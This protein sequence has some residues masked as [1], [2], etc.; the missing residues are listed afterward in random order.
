MLA[1]A[2][3]LRSRDR[4]RILV[5]IAILGCNNH[6]GTTSVDASADATADGASASPLGLTC[7]AAIAPN[8]CPAPA[9]TAGQASFCFRPGWS[10]VTGV[11]VYGKFGTATDWTAPFATLADDGSGTFVATVPLANGSYPYMFRIHGGADGV[12][13]DGSYV[14]DQTNPSFVPMV[15]GAPVQRS[16]SQ[17]TV[18]QTPSTIHHLRGTVSY[19]GAPQP[20]FVVQLDVGQ[21]YKPGGAPLS[22]HYIANFVESGPDGTFDFPVADGP[23][24]VNARFPFHLAGATTYPDPMSTPAIGVARTGTKMAGADV[25]LDVVDVAYPHADYVALAPTTGTAT[26]PVTFNWSVV[27]GATSAAVSVIGTSIAGNDPA[28]ISTYGTQTSESWDGTLLGGTHVVSGTTYWWGTWQKRTVGA[29]TWTEE[30]LLFP[31]VF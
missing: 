8:P 19:A 12:T 27:A 30:S 3:E 5:A 24:I 23:V 14:L 20:C 21:L 16:L 25:T 13:R 9:G 18:P 4:V 28:Y 10:G 22:E 31:I 26:L 11:D 17:I 6:A 29:T 1:L 15:A 7:A 2:R